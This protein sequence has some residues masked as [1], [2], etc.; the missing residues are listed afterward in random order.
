MIEANE[1]IDLVTIRRQ[2]DLAASQHETQVAATHAVLAR[3]GLPSGEV[4]PQSDAPQ[5]VVSVDPGAA[6][7]ATGV[8]AAPEPDGGGVRL[9]ITAG[10]VV[11]LF[12]VW[13]FQKRSARAS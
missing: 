2:Q 7:P 4:P 12:V 10:L 9:A 13:A 6:Q 5:P 8:P 11:V 3:G 1:N